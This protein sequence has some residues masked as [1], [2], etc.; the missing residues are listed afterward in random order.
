MFRGSVRSYI[1]K[2]CHGSNSEEP[3]CFHPNTQSPKYICVFWHLK[4]K[5]PF[6]L[7]LNSVSANP[8]SEG[9]AHTFILSTFE[10][11]SYKG[12]S[13]WESLELIHAE[14]EAGEVSLGFQPWVCRFKNK[15]LQA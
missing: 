4:F 5:L 6:L 3:H 1:H 2:L 10:S 8:L 14:R 13:D 7:S 12:P 9:G 11:K 15:T